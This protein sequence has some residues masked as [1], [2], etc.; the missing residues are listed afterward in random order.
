MIKTFYKPVIDGNT[1]IPI[2][3]IYKTP[4]VNIIL[5]DRGL[6]V[7]PQEPGTR[8]GC[9]LLPLTLNIALEVLIR[10]IRQEK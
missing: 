8:H 6:E 7:F 1:L 9:L 5:T 2:K 4:T 3:G 10:A